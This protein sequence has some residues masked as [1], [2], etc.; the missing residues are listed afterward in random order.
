MAYEQGVPMP[1][2]M[3]G[4]H[5]GALGA[6]FENRI[7]MT[8]RLYQNDRLGVVKKNYPKA[9]RIRGRLQ[10]EAATTV[11]FD[12]YLKDVGFV[13]FEAKT[14]QEAKWR[15]AGDDLGQFCYLLRGQRETSRQ[16]ARFFYLIEQRSTGRVFL[17]ENLEEMSNS[18][19]YEFNSDHIVPQKNVM[20]DYRSALR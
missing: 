7:I 3:A 2:E 10:Y 11:D 4:T 1:Y 13:A 14:T 17:A 18:G 16:A 6:T 8:N 20:L 9:A 12:G 5:S 15:V 19:F